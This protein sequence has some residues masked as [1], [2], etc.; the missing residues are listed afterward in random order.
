MYDVNLASAQDII[1]PKSKFK[2]YPNPADKVLTVQFED[3]Y[4]CCLLEITDVFGQVIKTK[5]LRGKKL[6]H[7]IDIS[8]LVPG[9]YFVGIV[10]D[11]KS[12]NAIRFMVR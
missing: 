1:S 4:D 7:S 8:E 12:Y 3:E 10:T 2:I 6:A 11:K 9:N 5:K